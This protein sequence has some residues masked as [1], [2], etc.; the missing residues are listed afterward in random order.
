MTGRRTLLL[1]WIIA[2]II[3]SGVLI[4]GIG[5]ADQVTSDGSV[6]SSSTYLSGDTTI[7]G[8]LFGSDRTSIDRETET[9][10]GLSRLMAQSDGPLL[11]GGYASYEEEQKDHATCFFGN[12]TSKV[13]FSP[14]FVEHKLDLSPVVPGMHCHPSYL[15]DCFPFLD[16][17]G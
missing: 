15:S 13:I 17:Q 14:M 8:R 6:M 10:E 16:R 3:T 11:I 2:G 1:L 5:I 12:Y 4:N 7:I 9:G